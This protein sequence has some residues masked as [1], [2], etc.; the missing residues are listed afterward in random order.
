MLGH[1]ERALALA[2]FG[3][4]GQFRPLGI[5]PAGLSRLGRRRQSGSKTVPSPVLC[6]KHY[7]NVV[8][9][10]STADWTAELSRPISLKNGKALATLSDARA[11]RISTFP[12][13]VRHDALALAITLLMT[14]AESRR[15]KDRRAATEQVALVL[16]RR[17]VLA[18]SPV[19]QVERERRKRSPA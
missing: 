10:P 8:A 17:G 11:C 13:V 19:T 7:T 4:P 3:E 2:S 1:Q 18:D 9:Y 5:Y 6:S 12:N 15:P 14:A 16:L